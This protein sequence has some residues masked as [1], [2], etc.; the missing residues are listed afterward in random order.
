MAAEAEQRAS[1][2]YSDPKA[3]AAAE[4]R[5][6]AAL[7]R[8]FA[9]TPGNPELRKAVLELGAAF[10]DLAAEIDADCSLVE[11]A[12]AWSCPHRRRSSP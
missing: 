6:N 11:M 5:A 9:Q 1:R 10:E 4:M 2:V 3:M 8:A 12:D 7:C